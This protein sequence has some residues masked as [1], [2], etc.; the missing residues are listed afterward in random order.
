MTG[1]DS[2]S[3]TPATNATADAGAINWAEGQ[4]PSTVNNTARQWMAD[5][6][7]RHNDLIW[8]QYGTGDQGAGNVA[9]PAVYSSGTV[10]TIAGADVT[11]AYHVGRRLRAVGS[12]TGTI[13]GTISVTSY[14][15][16]TTT[17]TAVWDSGSLSNET[18]VISLC[19]IPITGSPLGAIKAWTPFDASAAILTFAIATGSS[20]R[21]GNI[22]SAYGKVQYPATVSEA[23]NF[24]G[25]LPNTLANQ[26]YAQGG[27]V[28]TYCNEPTAAYVMATKNSTGFAVYDSSGVALTNAALSG[29]TLW[30]N[31]QYPLT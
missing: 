16:S 2:Y 19:Q 31:I 9:V 5:T 24:I 13:Y 3:T 11:A 29:K 15:P 28:L 20:T 22:V 17:V 27:G 12:G 4:A 30:F 8:F 26:D 7:A 1:I 6:R 18:L 10:F 14:A 23:S 21:I 25:G